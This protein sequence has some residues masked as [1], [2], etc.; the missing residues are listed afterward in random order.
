MRYLILFVLLVAVLISAG[1][2]S[3][4]KVTVVP[5]T[6]P[7]T[8]I[9]KDTITTLTQQ[10]Q[11]KNTSIQNECSPPRLKSGFKEF[12]QFVKQDSSS[13]MGT[14][15]PVFTV[16]KYPAGPIVNDSVV[17][18]FYWWSNLGYC[19]F[20]DDGIWILYAWDNQPHYYP[21]IWR[22][23]DFK[24]YDNGQIYVIQIVRPSAMGSSN[25]TESLSLN[26]NVE[27]DRLY[28]INYDGIDYSKFADAWVGRLRS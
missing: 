22:K 24:L 8:P 17:G 14:G 27:K 18:K 1:C 12:D 3:D 6:Q 16:P 4:N 26:Y 21:G 10:N 7:P 5:S 28:L 19:E 11:I 2:V 13:C 20:R 25:Y 9:P 23:S 15:A